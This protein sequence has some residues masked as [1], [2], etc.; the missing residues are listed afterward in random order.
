MLALVQTGFPDPVLT[1]TQL[2]EVLPQLRHFTPQDLGV[3]ARGAAHPGKSRP[4]ATRWR[5]GGVAGAERC[6]R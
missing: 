2:I 1:S 4:P 3:M 5:P 6:A